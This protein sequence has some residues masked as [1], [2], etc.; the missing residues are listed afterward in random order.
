MTENI[1]ISIKTNQQNYY[2]QTMPTEQEK[3]DKLYEL[4]HKFKSQ[5]AD[6]LKRQTR[7][8]EKVS[9][10]IDEEKIKKIREKIN[11]L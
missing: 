2:F 4:F 6:L 11:K 8:M 1:T 3:I 9:R 5:I 7:L 10:L